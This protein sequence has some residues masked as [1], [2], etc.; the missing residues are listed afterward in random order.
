V[1]STTPDAPTSAWDVFKSQIPELE[2]I[3]S[4]Q[5]PVTRDI[6]IL[7]LPTP[8]PSVGD[9]PV[10]LAVT[11]TPETAFLL[12]TY[13]RT[14]A[15]WMDLLDFDLTYQLSIP[16]VA[17]SS[18]LLFHSICAFT[19]RHLSLSNSRQQSSWDPVARFHYGESLRLLIAALNSPSYKHALTATLLVSSYEILQALSSE[20]HS[21]HFMGAAMLIKSQGIN[22]NSVGIDRA[23]FWV[24]VRHDIGVALA[25]ERP[26][27]LHPDEWSV[28]W[29]ARETREDYL[30]NRVLWILGRVI[31]LVYGPNGSTVASKEGRELFLQE[32]GE[33]RTGLS[34]SFIGIPYG[35]AD[36]EGFRKVY[37]TVTAAGKRAILF[38][39]NT[40]QLKY[41]AA[42]A[43]WYHVCRILLYAEPTL[44][45]EAY[46]P[47]IQ[48]QAELIGNI[49]ISEFPDSLRVFATHGLYFAAKHI[50]GLAR[51]ARLWNILNDVEAQLGYHTK[52]TVQRLQKLVEEN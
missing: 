8:G 35:E 48:N 33:W 26:L 41:L 20:P 3:S 15:T 22:A 36:E 45:D 9:D 12:Q 39:F 1:A 25:Q 7:N 10:T 30:A 21:R 42:A 18:P 38:L 47:Q 52:S 37:F 17:L 32:L 29:R 28:S 14:V 13:L 27:T 11:L 23:N 2:S 16:R 24:F 46:I 49:A 51:K 34:D 40:S 4:N 31:N 6:P 19:A 43:F 50:N 5:S 44:Q